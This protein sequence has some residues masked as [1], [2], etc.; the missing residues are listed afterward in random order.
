MRLR[1]DCVQPTITTVSQD[2]LSGANGR[3]SGQRAQSRV[4]GVAI[5]TDRLPRVWGVVLFAASEP[6]SKALLQS[7]RSFNRD[8]CD[9]LATRIPHQKFNMSC[10]V[11][12]RS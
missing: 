7:F 12:L 10:L 6:C 5:R 3:L 4:S 11:L 8:H 2:L 9:T 1:D